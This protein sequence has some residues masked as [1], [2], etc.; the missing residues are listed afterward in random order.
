[1]FVSR[2]TYFRCT[3]LAPWLFAVAEHF[4]Q[5][6]GERPDVTRAGHLNGSQRFWRAPGHG[7]TQFGMVSRCRVGVVRVGRRRR[8]RLVDRHGA[9]RAAAIEQHAEGLEQAVVG[10]L[11]GA[12]GVEARQH[13][14][15]TREVAVN[16]ASLLQI[17]HGTGDLFGEMAQV[18]G[19]DGDTQ[20]GI[21]EHVDERSQRCQ[22]D[23]HRR[24]AVLIS[25]AAED[26]E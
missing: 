22:L 25:V 14:V 11:H 23:D 9:Y 26:V 20:L 5:C 12:T 15:A 6:D 17:R 2:L 10:H 16:D 1:M 19:R 8:R 3:Q 13:D 21:A 7:Q 18:H 4:P 24:L